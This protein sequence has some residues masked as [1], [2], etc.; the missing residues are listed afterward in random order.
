MLWSIDLGEG[1]RAGYFDVLYI[2]NIAESI[3]QIFTP[4]LSM[5]IT[6]QTKH[7]IMTSGTRTP[8]ILS[9]YRYLEHHLYLHL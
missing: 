3:L 2:Q 1:K 9:V 4:S 6:W 8:T 5:L 7:A